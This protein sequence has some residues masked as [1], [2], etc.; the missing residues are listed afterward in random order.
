MFSAFRKDDIRIWND[1]FYLNKFE[2]SLLRSKIVTVLLFVEFLVRLSS[3]VTWPDLI[4]YLSIILSPDL[5]TGYYTDRT[6]FKG[7]QG[8]II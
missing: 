5:S 6:L 8:W 7:I 1:K 4:S 3:V 2:I